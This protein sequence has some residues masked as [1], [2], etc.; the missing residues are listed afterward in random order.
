MKKSPNTQSLKSAAQLP[1]PMVSVPT[2]NS[3]TFALGTQVVVIVMRVV[4]VMVMV[5]MVAVVL[6]MMVMMV[7]VMVMNKLFPICQL[8]IGGQ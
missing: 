7:R 1:P 3:S 4:M 6:V 5:M 2:T 8:H